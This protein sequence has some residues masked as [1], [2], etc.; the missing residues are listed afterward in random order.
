MEKDERG[1]TEMKYLLCV[2]YIFFSVTGLTCIKLGSGQT[3]NKWFSVPFLQIGISRITL[4][5]ILCYGISFCLYLSVISNFQ[6]GIVVPVIGGIVNIA[7]LLVCIFILKENLS[8]NMIIGAVFII[9]GILIMNIK[10]Q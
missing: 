9:I 1:R 3:D 2:I 8:A 7:I 6:L 4:L 10:K 5:G